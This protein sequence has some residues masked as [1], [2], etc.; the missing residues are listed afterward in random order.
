[1]K[2]K[3]VQHGN[4]SLTISLPINW[5]KRFNLR[6]GDELDITEKDKA[7][8]VSTDNA[9]QMDHKEIDISGYDERT[10]VWYLVSLYKSG[11]DESK[12]VFGNHEQMTIIQQKINSLLGYS[13]MEQRENYCI[14]RSISQA[15]EQEFEPALRRT[16]L[17]TIS[18]AE[19]TYDAFKAKQ[20]EAFGSVTMMEETNNQLVAF[21]HRLLNKHGYHNS[22]KTTYVYTIVWLLENIADNY[23]DMM[24]KIIKNNYALTYSDE[25]LATFAEVNLLLRNFYEMFY[26][27]DNDTVLKVS[28]KT[29]ELF[30]RIMELLE[31]GNRTEKHILY[32]LNIIR[33]LVGESI[34]AVLG[35]RI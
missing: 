9:F 11:Y 8:I 5:A 20:K 34:G 23:R 16:F 2:R 12:I 26:K 17:V 35:L 28:Q 27:L 10:I 30:D 33:N 4:T 18:M 15:V 3:I 21:C 7:L 22:A 19:S 24:G 31:E 25:V 13:I 6:K 29:A 1:M 32:F 14:I